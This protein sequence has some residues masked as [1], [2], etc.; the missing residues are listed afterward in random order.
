YPRG[1]HEWLSEESMAR[2]WLTQFVGLVGAA[3]TAAGAAPAGYSSPAADAA[4]AP[5]T[6]PADVK[7]KDGVK[8]YLLAVATQCN[9]ASKSL[10]TH[11]DEYAALIKQSGG[12]YAKAAKAD[13]ANIA[14][15]VKA[16]QGDYRRIDSY[17]YEYIEGIVAGV[18]SLA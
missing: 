16:M 17:G 15:L 6:V 7:G 14:A 1:P 12:D 9:D 4:I 18:P 3:L 5:P 10:K 13:P 2:R 8:A 11:A